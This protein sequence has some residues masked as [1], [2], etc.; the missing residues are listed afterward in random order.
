MR[1][2]GATFLWAILLLLACSA[3]AQSSEP[4]IAQFQT[5]Q[6][7]L[8]D[9]HARK[10]WQANL[11]YA[12][13]QRS[14]LNGSP[15]S[16]LE[17]ARA[18]LFLGSNAAGLAELMRYAQMGQSVDAA[19]LAPNWQALA[20]EPGFVRLEHALGENRKAIARGTPVFALSDPALLAEDI[21]YDSHAQLFYISSVREKKIIT[22]DVHGSSREFAQ[23]PDAW[24]IIALK[25][26]LARGRLWATE[27]AMQG[28]EFAPSADWGKSV[29][30]CFDLKSRAVLKRVAGPHASALGDMVLTKTGDVIVSDGDGGGIYRLRVNGTELDRVDHGD[31]ISPQTAALGPDDRH[32]FV[33]DYLRGI[34]VLDLES[35][36]VQWIPM[37]GRF[38]LNGIDGLYY[39]HG[40]LIAV[41][42]GTSP[43]RVV[44]FRLQNS[45]R[46]V[47]AEEI[48][49]RGTPTLGDP[50]H[51]VIVGKSFYYI[52]NSGWDVIDEHGKLKNGAELSP[53]RL[54][55]SD[56]SR[57]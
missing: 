16:R 33:P 42:N 45:K 40:K 8:H 24:P 39:S 17:V 30:L 31:F 50:T 7:G 53:P 20:H 36:Q 15:D 10:D 35:G 2:R 48:I 56:L 57:L 52:A 41:Q 46:A 14:L 12:L 13:R 34:A 54:M 27:V 9:S 6:K 25:V 1:V 32:L 23:A 11:K 4:A 49:E 19:P 29:L 37:T 55:R 22:V 51:G 28:Y 26:D 3:P 5:L 44:V 18:E 38:A 21:D 43:E 47:A